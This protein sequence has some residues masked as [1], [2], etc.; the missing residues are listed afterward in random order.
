MRPV[1]ASEL[2]LNGGAAGRATNSGARTRPSRM[3][4]SQGGGRENGRR[5]AAVVRSLPDL[6]GVRPTQLLR[7]CRLHGVRREPARRSRPP[8][9][10]RRRL[11]PAGATRIGSTTPRRHGCGRVMALVAIAGGILVYRSLRA[12]HWAP[13][14]GAV[15]ETGRAAAPAVDAG[16]VA[17]RT[18][19]PSRGRRIARATRR[20]GGSSPRGMPSGRSALSRRRRPRHSP[21]PGRGPRLRPRARAGGRR[22]PRAL[23][24]RARV[25]P[26]AGDRDL[27]LDLIRALARGRPARAGGARAGGGARARSRQSGR[28]GAAGQ[29]R[30]DDGRRRFSQHG[31]RRRQ[32]FRQFAPRTLGRIVHERRPRT[33]SAAR[34]SLVDPPLRPVGCHQTPVCAL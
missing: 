28:G 1:S 22:G 3:A 17:R 14:P 31:S 13:L 30:G 25:A 34:Q 5:R 23:P 2:R 32:R 12:P 29:P 26:R 24:A 9:L 4:P 16:R 27:S 11:S 19:R 15:T 8:R 33:A 20:A 6:P 21:R 10:L 18:C 7:P